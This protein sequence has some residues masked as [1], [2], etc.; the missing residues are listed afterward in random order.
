MPKQPKSIKLSRTKIDLFL[1][2]QCCFWLDRVKNIKRPSGPPFSLNIAVDHLMKKEFDLLR[3]K[4]KKHPLFTQYDLDLTPFKHE[5]MDQWRGRTGLHF[6]DPNNDFDV[7]GIID[8]I[9][10]DRKGVLYIADYKATA[11]TEEVEWT[12]S[13]WHNQY[14]R[15]L[16]LYQWLLRGNGFK[17]SDTAYLV[18]LNCRKDAERFDGKLEF[19]AK[20]LTHHGRTDWIEPTIKKIAACLRSSKIPIASE[21]CEFC[22]YRQAAADGVER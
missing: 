15:Q 19:E 13:P 9:W 12:D 3:A 6:L 16:E 22:R 5:K 21:N 2:C 10:V 7:F 17:V 11:K 4:S 18:Y 20:I 8:D 14:R 1:E